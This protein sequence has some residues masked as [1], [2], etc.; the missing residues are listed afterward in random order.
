MREYLL[1]IPLLLTAAQ[2]D[3]DGDGI[4][5]PARG[6]LTDRDADGSFD[7]PG[8]PAAPVEDDDSLEF[9]PA[10]TSGTVLNNQWD[11]TCGYLDHDSLLDIVGHHW[12]PNQLHVFEADGSGSYRHVWQQ[13][14]SMPP[15]SYVSVT[16]GDPDDDGVPEIIGAD[17]STLG[18][19]VVFENL[20]NDTWGSPCVFSAARNE[21]IRTVRVADTDQDDTNEIVVITG[22][23]DGGGVYIF[24]HSGP[25]G[26]HSYAL[27]HHYSTVSYLFQ[28]EIGDADNDGYPEVLLGVG[29]MHGFP[30]YIRRIVYDPAG[31]SYSH[32]LFQSSVIGLHLSPIASDIDSSGNHEL[33]VGSSGDPAGQ[34][35]AFK[36]VGDDSFQPLCSSGFATSGNLIAVQA[37]AFAGFARPVVCAA[38]FSGLVHCV[39]ADQ[40]VWRMVG[41]ISPGTG[42]AIRSIDVAR[43]VRDELILAESAP[44]DFASVYRR[45]G[46]QGI[47]RAAVQP[48]RPG[49]AVVPNPT[50]GTIRLSAPAGARFSVIDAAGRLV[51]RL[52]AGARVLSGLRPGVYL[53]RARSRTWS[54]AVRL[55]VAP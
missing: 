24:E 3:L 44:S 36:Y 35:H 7:P 43:D 55:L 19:V 16:A 52:P 4:A 32:K 46:T 39:V 40:A 51:A 45:A 50:P 18:K 31:R 6:V 1:L 30:M 23:T 5:E 41:S 22:N 25:A 48:V 11:A 38:A 49:L 54:G 27:R 53:V 29:G 15:A 42:A 34:L 17:G 10:W 8:P 13:A 14:E 2:F 9:Q 21:R 26:T 47:D 28:G 20:G 33:V 12:N 37:G